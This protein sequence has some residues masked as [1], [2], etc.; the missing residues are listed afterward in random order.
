M[1][2]MSAMETTEPIPANPPRDLD[3]ETVSLLREWKRTQPAYSKLSDPR[4]ASH[5][6]KYE[7][8][9]AVLKPKRVAF[10]DSLVIVGDRTNW[11]AA[12]IEALFDI[13]LYPS[14]VERRH[15]L[16]KVVYFSE[17]SAKDASHDPYRRFGNAG[18]VLYAQDEDS[19]EAV[20]SVGE[21]LCH[22]AMT[23]GV[24]TAISRGH[25]HALPLIQVRFSSSHATNDRSN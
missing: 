8:S 6:G 15:T 13:T 19:H 23:S 12:Q 14:G 4:Q 2:D 21:I 18:R 10:G 5:L 1:S 11:R 25:I 16:A 17:L 22:F 20:I 7:H 9:G 24:C 3:R